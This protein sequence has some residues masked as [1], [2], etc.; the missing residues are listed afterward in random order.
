MRKILAL[1]ILAAPAWA[2]WLESYHSGESFLAQGR[3][4]NALE[5]LQS[6]ARQAETS[7]A[8]DAQLA[9]VYD[10]LGRG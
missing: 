1:T 2:D 5:C 8:P 9:V 7:G 3:T 10:A 4:A 6:A